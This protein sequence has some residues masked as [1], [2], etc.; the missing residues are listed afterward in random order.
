MEINMEDTGIE[1]DF[2][3]ISLPDLLEEWGVPAD[4]IKE[5]EETWLEEEDEEQWQDQ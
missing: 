2:Y 4:V 5:M 1:G 3:I